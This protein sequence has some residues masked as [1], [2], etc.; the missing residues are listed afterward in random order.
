[1]SVIDSAKS[2]AEVRNLLAHNPQ[3]MSVYA[4]DEGKVQ[5]IVEEV[6]RH[7]NEGQRVSYQELLKHADNARRLERE[8]WSAISRLAKVLG[9]TPAA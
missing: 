5:R 8:F 9:K 6:S 7:R 2:L 1:M 4:D 3:R